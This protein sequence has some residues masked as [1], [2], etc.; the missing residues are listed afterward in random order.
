MAQMVVTAGIDVSKGWL[1]AALWPKQ[2]AIHVETTAA[3]YDEFLSTL[4]TRG[5]GLPGDLRALRKK[6]LAAAASRLA[7][8]R[9]SIV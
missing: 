2:G 9:K 4:M 1:D 7:V 6:C 3:G 8:S 5:T